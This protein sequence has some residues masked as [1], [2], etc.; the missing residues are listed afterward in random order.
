MLRLIKIWIRFYCIRF[1][2]AMV[3]LSN[4][5]KA[6]E[7]ITEELEEDMIEYGIKINM[8]KT[9]IMRLNN[10]MKMTVMTSEGIIQVE[11]LD[12]EK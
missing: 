2:E 8:M 10:S 3:V 11:S 9:K 4:N 1:A 6:L 7:R 12:F 5:N